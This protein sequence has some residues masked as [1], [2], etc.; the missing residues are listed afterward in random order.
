VETLE[1]LDGEYQRLKACLA[2]FAARA[3]VVDLRELKGLTDELPGHVQELALA[4][5]IKLDLAAAQRCGLRRSLFDYLQS[6]G[7]PL[8]EHRVSL[9]LIVEDLQLRRAA[10]Q[11]LEIERYAA[12]WPKLL[13][14]LPESKQ[15]AAESQTPFLPEEPPPQL[16]MGQHIDDFSIL[17]PLGQG[18]FAHVYLARQVSMHRLV[19]LKVSTRPCD[20][21]AA[22]AQLDHP[23]IVRVYDQRQWSD[24]RAHVLYMQY[25][26]GGTLEDVVRQTSQTNISQR[27][28]DLLLD[29]IDRALL[30]GG[31][32]APENSPVR[33][34]IAGLT[35]PGVVAWIGTQLASA[36]AYAH[37]QRMLHRDV[38]PANVLLTADGIPKLADFNV[39]Y[40]GLAGRAGAATYFGGS[41]AYMSPEQLRVANP[42]DPL[43]AELLD[44]RSDL[45]SLA[46][47]LWEVWQGRRPWA[48]TSMPRNWQSG[49]EQLLA[50]RDEHP[51]VVVPCQTAAER[52][53]ERTLRMT[54]SPRP[55]QRPRDGE[56]LAGRLRLVLQPQVA[57]W[58][59]PA[60][61]S[62]HARLLQI[63]IFLLAGAMVFLPNVLSSVFNYQY[64]R[65]QIMHLYPELLPQFDRLSEFV[66]W[67][68]F[69]LGIGM[70]W[71][72][73]RP[74]SQAIKA[75]RTG[76]PAS[77]RQLSAA[78]NL[79]HRAAL[80][81]GCLWLMAGI[82]FPI[83]LQ[84][85]DPDFRARDAI[86]FILSMVL[87][88]GVA[89]IYP[90]FGL[91]WFAV[92]VLF[93]RLL[94]TTMSDPE[95]PQRSEQLRRRS[96]W[97]L[98]SAAA[99]PLLA[100]G[101]LAARP[102]SPRVVMLIA[103]VVTAC[104]LFASYLAHGKIENA[105]TQ[106]SKVLPATAITKRHRQPA[107]NLSRLMLLLASTT[108]SVTASADE[109]AF[110][111][112][113]PILID[114]CLI[115]H[116]AQQSEGGY[117]LDTP[118]AMLEPGDSQ[119]APLVRGDLAASELY[120]RLIHADSDLRMP[121][122]GPP[123]DERDIGAIAQWI[124]QGAEIPEVQID[125]PMANLL[126][127][128]NGTPPEH[129]PPAWPIAAL[130]LDDER[131]EVIV[132]GYHELLVFDRRT[133]SLIRRLGDMPQR[134]ADIA[135][136]PD[137]RQLAVAGG[138]PGRRG[139]V[140]L[141][142][143]PAGHATARLAHASDMQLCIAFAP[144][145]Q[146]IYVGGSDGKLVAVDLA[147][148]RIVGSFGGHSDWILALSVSA[149]GNFLA[150][151]SRD[152]TA[153]RLRTDSLSVEASF[154]G[155]GRSVTAVLV[156]ADGSRAISGDEQGTV[157]SWSE[158]GEEPQRRA[159]VAGAVL[160][161]QAS[162]PD[163]YIFS[164]NRGPS[165]WDLGTLQPKPWSL[166]VPNTT[167]TAFASTEDLIGWG[168]A[169]AAWQA[170]VPE[171]PASLTAPALLP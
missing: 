136:S 144:D 26:P 156:S 5:M 22:L 44:G 38:K 10:G 19:A 6:A 24:Q 82:L 86:R 67:T 69:P 39:C 101:L 41:L 87:C 53:L 9:D 46:V 143:W 159:Q 134:V 52:A 106:L 76:S 107:R 13:E 34:E 96:G 94:A 72:F 12:R 160:G 166:H 80:I 148:R 21:P 74:I 140:R 90:F 115:C 153:K 131:G 145:S 149:D 35:W 81:G 33:Q 32:S 57:D 162:G 78:W 61:H 95:F 1:T 48:I 68:F 170:V 18:A 93:P 17:N 70:L 2:S 83:A 139:D 51:E 4:E 147:A 120:Q 47:T 109:P 71:Y 126:N 105:I 111:A 171:M 30:T 14:Q 58:F 164:A 40:S 152:R 133:G 25:L 113:A 158:S 73:T 118:R 165:R 161:F 100:L 28:G 88:G 119:R 56:E 121:A 91:T 7:G 50:Q 11:P 155:H 114:R 65:S 141:F 168:T 117:R 99:I 142:D 75:A 132:G 16:A 43:T 27:G 89:W 110:S 77:E 54:L 102:D 8:A 151:G 59:E 45:Y 116:N 169:R 150:T 138:I 31:Q 62:F 23:N 97:Y 42:A 167:Y 108:A 103:V 64:N 66:N 154:V 125:D 36:L 137:R 92:Q 63:P 49:I 128:I 127:D 122:D 29:A 124:E 163:L 84:W 85:F 60:P 55:E 37:Q 79:G 98:I 15:N 135:L 112:V 129:Y 123:L 130:E 3:P 20:E 146:R 157:M 104:A